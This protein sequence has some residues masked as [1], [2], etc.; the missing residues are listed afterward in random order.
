MNEELKNQLSTFLSK[1]LDIAE[2]GIDTAGEQIPALL[3]EIVYWQ[4]SSNSILF[5]FGIILSF[6]A[7]KTARSINLEKD[8]DDPCIILSKAI[9]LISSGIGCVPLLVCSLDAVK[10]LV[11]PRLV[12]LEY[13]KGLL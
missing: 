3:Q 6:V 5:V 1:A 9:L 13:L 7:Y 11:A 8:F 2:K 10:A 4:I 12:I